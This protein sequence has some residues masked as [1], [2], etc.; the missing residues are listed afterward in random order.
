MYRNTIISEGNLPNHIAI[1]MDGNGRW[2]KKRLM[3]RSFGH[4]A[5]W[6]RLQ[7]LVQYAFEQGVSVVTL[8]ALSTENLYRPKTELDAL[9]DILRGGM[10]KY[11]EQ[12][13]TKNIQI[14]VIGD[15]SLLPSDVQ[16]ILQS[17]QTH[18]E[19]NSKKCLQIALAYGA[20]AELV[21][22]VNT[23]IKLGEAVDEKSFARLLY[24]RGVPDPDLIIRTG[25]EQR[26][27]NFLL[28]QSAYSELYFSKKP[29]PDFTNG[30]L[31]RALT[32]YAGRNRRY[33][34]TDEQITKDKIF[35]G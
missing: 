32:A 33:G 4:E 9:F 20:R 6:K 22:A 13:R 31:S 27:S 3:P 25:G 7:T 16:A 1:I 17:V 26:L 24:T 18:S 30:D 10:E 14:R 29:F 19:R 2:A 15:I 5:G 12:L 34:K 11:A 21:R 28:Y 35:H 8:Y 23:A